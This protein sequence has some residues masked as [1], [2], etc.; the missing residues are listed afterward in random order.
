MSLVLIF[1]RKVTLTGTNRSA[2]RACCVKIRNVPA[3]TWLCH[4]VQA[5]LAIGLVKIVQK[6]QI[7]RYLLQ[8]TGPDSFRNFLIGNEQ[9][10]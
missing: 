3:Y 10:V 8:K 5:L 1:T 7:I 2:G 4:F 6:A 9:D